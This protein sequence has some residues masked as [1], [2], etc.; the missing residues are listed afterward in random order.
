MKRGNKS[1]AYD[2]REIGYP[3]QRQHSVLFGFLQGTMT[4]PLLLEQMVNVEIKHKS[5]LKVDVQ[6]GAGESTLIVVGKGL[7][8]VSVRI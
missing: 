6:L 3:K 1:L 7:R 2:I 4:N 8:F 5:S